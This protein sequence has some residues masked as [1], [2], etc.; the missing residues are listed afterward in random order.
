MNKYKISDISVGK[1]EQFE[2]TITEEIM[3]KF[4]EMSGDTNPMHTDDEYARKGGYKGAILH[5]MCVASFYSTLVGVYLPGQY[6]LF[7]KCDVEWPAP[8]YVG[9]SLCVKGTVKQIDEKTK[10]LFINAEIRNQDD[11]KVSRAKLI[12]AVQGDEEDG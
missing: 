9:D 5:G 10:R 12:V 7:H 1:S 3:K 6:C 11:V 4:L 8:V 2:V